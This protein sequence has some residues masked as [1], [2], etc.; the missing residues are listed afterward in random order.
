MTLDLQ[1]LYFIYLVL[2]YLI[3][4]MPDISIIDISIFQISFPLIT[5]EVAFARSLFY[6]FY[7]RVLF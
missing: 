3:E 4:V 7:A 5:H 6:Q 2:Q 1:I